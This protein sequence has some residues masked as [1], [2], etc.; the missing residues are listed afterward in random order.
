MDPILR[1]AGYCGKGMMI[2]LFLLALIYLFFQEKNKNHRM[3]FLYMPVVT[4]IIY[5]C[6]LF[7]MAVYRFLGE[8]L[9]WRFLWLLPVVV[10]IAYASVKII[11]RIPGKKKT[12]AGIVLAVFIMLSGNL[13]YKSE[14]A[15][16]SG[17]LY[18]LPQ[19]VIDICERIEPDVYEVRAAFPLELVSYVRQY[20]ARVEMPYGRDYLLYDYAIRSPLFLALEE[21]TLNVEKVTSLAREAECEY[22][23]FWKGKIL[24]GDFEDYGFEILGVYGDYLLVQDKQ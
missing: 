16:Y 23:V 24:N 4:L 21:E 20:A 14:H 22:L 3:I 6:P 11:S 18:H 5:F 1:F 2:A 19:C 8:D 12:M 17:N 10:V 13:I 7:S 15:F 9:Y